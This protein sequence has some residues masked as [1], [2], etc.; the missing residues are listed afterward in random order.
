VL[1]I[2]AVSRRHGYGANTRIALIARGLA[3]MTRLG[4]ARRRAH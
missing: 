2:G 1:A 3:E 4:E